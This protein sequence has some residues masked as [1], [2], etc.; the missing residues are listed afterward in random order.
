MN[1][2][3]HQSQWIR[4]ARAYYASALANG[5]ASIQDDF[6]FSADIAAQYAAVRHD[7]IVQTEAVFG[8]VFE[9]WAPMQ[10]VSK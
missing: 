9:Q 2:A 7:A 4:D 10:R 1:A 6:S 3:K 8:Y 5:W